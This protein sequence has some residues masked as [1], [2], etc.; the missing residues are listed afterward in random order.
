[1]HTCP[2]GARGCTAVLHGAA[3][4]DAR[5]AQRQQ[6][7][8]RGG[9][10]DQRAQ[11]PQR[12]AGQQHAR[13]ADPAGQRGASV[14]HDCPAVAS[15]TPSNHWCRLDSCTRAPPV[16]C[17]AATRKAGTFARPQAPP[18]RSQG[19]S[20]A[21][22]RRVVGRQ[23]WHKSSQHPRAAPVQG[24]CYAQH[25]VGEQGSTAEKHGVSLMRADRARGTHLVETQPAGICVSEYL[26]AARP[27]ISSL[28]KP[29]PGAI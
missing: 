18:D 20:T 14:Q 5:G 8:V 4:D 11:R 2:Q 27:S 24:I 9:R 22:G 1:M 28:A 13:A 3:H 29:V 10:R 21:P 7:G 6:A 12:H 19:V 26:H 17:Q 25:A 15:S 16:R 23:A